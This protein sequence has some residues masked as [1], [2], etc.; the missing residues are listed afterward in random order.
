MNQ[1][2]KQKEVQQVLIDNHLSICAILE[3]HVSEVMLNKVCGRVFRNWRWASNMVMCVKSPRIIIGWNPDIVDLMFLAQSDQVIHTQV[4]LKA[5]NKSVF[6]SFIYAHNQYIQRRELWD[7]LSLHKRFVGDNPWCLLGD[8]NAT[9][10]LNDNTSGASVMDIA[11]R[12]FKECVTDIEVVD[13]NRI[14]LQFTWNQKPQGNNGILKKL[15]RILANVKFQ[16]FF[17]CCCFI[18]A[19]QDF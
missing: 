13:I 11:L 7:N 10:D 16:C 8:F 6:C 19:L 9:L 15:D 1:P 14:G 3:S 2:P 18:S 4:F 5:D 17:R 12:E